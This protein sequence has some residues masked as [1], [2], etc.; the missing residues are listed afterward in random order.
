MVICLTSARFNMKADI[1]KATGPTETSVGSGEWVI[2]HDPDSNEI[3]R[4]WLP[5]GDNPDTP[6]VENN[7]L[8]SF[9][10]LARGIVD[11]G[12][13]VAGTTERFSE[14]YQGIDYVRIWFPPKTDINRRDRITNI[15]GPRGDIIWREEERID[16]APTIFAVVG[17]TP[18]ID[19]FGK[20]IESVAML[21]RVENQ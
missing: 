21:E 18:I 1:L 14:I 7:T 13:R 15:R 19:P 17:V 3:T 20:H 9:R 4:E 11:G 16:N 5:A 10:C 6:E 2:G 8:Q 12:I